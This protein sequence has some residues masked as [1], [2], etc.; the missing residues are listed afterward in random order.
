MQVSAAPLPGGE[1]AARCVFSWR[2]FFADQAINI[3]ASL[4]A[5]L[6]LVGSLSFTATTSSLLLSFL[7]VFLVHAVFGITGFIT[8]RFPNF[9]VVATIYTVI[10][11]LLV[12]LV[13]FSAYRLFTGNNSGF[14]VP[15][16]VAIT[17]VYAAIMYTVLAIYQRFIPFAYL[18]MVALVVADLAV[19]AAFQLAYWWWPSIAIVLAFPALV[20]VQRLAGNNWPFAGSWAVLRDPVRLVMYALVSACGLAFL[21]A[22]SFQTGWH[23]FAELGAVGLG[24]AIT[25]SVI[26]NRAGAGKTPAKPAWCWLLLLSG[27]LLNWEYGILV[28]VLD[29][30]PVWAFLGLVLLMVAVAVLARQLVGAA[31]AN[32]LDVLA[33]AGSALTLGLSLHQS[34]DVIGALLL[35]F[36][37]LAYVVLLYQRRQNW[38]FLP[39]IYALL[40]LPAL[41]DRPLVVLRIGVLLPL[42]SVVIQ[43]FIARRWSG[44]HAALLASLRLA[45]SWG[46]PL[47]AAG[48]IYGVTSSV[49]DVVFSTGTIQN[50]VGLRFPVA[51][52]PA[53]LAL[54]WYAS[55]ALARVKLWLVPSVAFALG[56]LL[57]PTNSFWVVLGLAPVLALLGIATSRF[58]GRDWA[59]PLYIAALRAASMTGYTGML[60]DHLAAAAWA[61]LGFA[62][63]AYV[64]GLV[65]NTLLPLWIMPV[66]ATWP[67]IIAAGF[68]GDLYRPSGVALLSAALG[69]TTRFLSLPGLVRRNR[70]LA[71]SLPFYATALAAAVLTGVYGTLADINRPFYAAVPDALLVY[72]LVAFAVL[73]FEKQSRWLWLAAGFAAWGTALM[74]ELTAYYML[75]TGIALALIGLA[76]GRLV[77][78]PVTSGAVPARRETLLKFTWSWPWYIVALLA[79]VLTGSWPG[80]AVSQPAAGFIGYSLLAFT[81]AALVIMLVER[82]PELLLFPAGLAAWAI[83][84]WRPPLDLVALMISY[85]LICLLTFA[86][87]FTW[88]IVSP[89]SRWLPATALHDIPV[90]AGRCPALAARALVQLQRQQP[91]PN[92]DPGR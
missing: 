7:V 53:L 31:W 71:Y 36:A 14:S 8:H 5:F 21:V 46:W 84:Q 61:L 19:A 70:L 75:G 57:I 88:R 43:R 81:A 66:F 1:Q 82:V 25:V 17:A 30:E 18:G 62:A 6:I 41:W 9:R 23:T 50:D 65:E 74:L 34:Q 89:A 72:A 27:F 4:G 22:T 12:P 58:A 15:A 20:A 77:K 11:A 59:L 85:S 13:G 35:S 39:L 3:V 32:P 28:L 91:A 44:A 48:L 80:L 26:L 52:E 63:Q 90:A 24:L 10:F 47:L 60:Q 56:A 55:A 38:L 37:A 64:I 83:W 73:V 42:V 68:L 16:L 87:Q 29:I 67:V 2:S 92:V 76:A 69:V 86:A 54:I 49:H 40:A 78:Q 45:N 33:L 79:A 51:V